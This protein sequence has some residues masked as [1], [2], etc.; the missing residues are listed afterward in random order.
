MKSR[1]D[2]FKIP[3]NDLVLCMLELGL[4]QNFI[5]RIF[6]DYPAYRLESLTKYF[7][8][9]KKRKKINDYVFKAALDSQSQG[10]STI[11]RLDMIF[12]L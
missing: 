2:D 6:N 10:R 8:N 9:K 5:V 11:K 7:Y 12:N 4:T 3:L 1:K